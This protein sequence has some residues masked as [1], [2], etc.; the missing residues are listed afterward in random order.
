MDPFFARLSVVF[1][2]GF[3]ALFDKMHWRH[4]HWPEMNL[5]SQEDSQRILR[6][7]SAAGK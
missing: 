4:R 1:M 3:V 6:I 2:I 7:L 5:M